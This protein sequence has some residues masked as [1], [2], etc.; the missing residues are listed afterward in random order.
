MFVVFI[1]IGIIQ[2]ESKVIFNENHEQE[3]HLSLLIFGA[4]QFQTNSI[5]FTSL[6]A[7]LGYV[8]IN[9][10]RL[11]LSL[12]LILL[13][14]LT[15]NRDPSLWVNYCVLTFTFVRFVHTRFIN[16]VLRFVPSRFMMITTH[17]FFLGSEWF[18]FESN[19]TFKW[20]N[21]N[22]SMF[23]FLFNAN[24]NCHWELIKFHAINHIA[25]PVT[26]Y[27]ANVE[28]ANKLDCMN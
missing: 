1:F 27:K 22:F 2:P 24:N 15:K 25:I 4:Q 6:C 17:F 11:I 12:N 26:I 5:H 14:C 20:S 21:K 8:F 16:F 13:F 18:S 19:V 23:Q 3:M 28:P 7:Y 10:S 9:W